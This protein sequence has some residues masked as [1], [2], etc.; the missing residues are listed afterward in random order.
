MTQTVNSGMGMPM[1]LLGGANSSA[2]AAGPVPVPM[3][4]TSAAAGSSPGT[5]AQVRALDAF[6]YAVAASS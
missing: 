3:M 2:A 1:G 4:D 5:D 6:Y